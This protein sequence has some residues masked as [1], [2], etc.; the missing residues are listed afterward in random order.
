MGGREYSGK[1][2]NGQDPSPF[3]GILNLHKEG[4]CIVCV[5][6]NAM[7]FDTSQLPTP[8]SLSKTLQAPLPPSPAKALILPMMECLG[9]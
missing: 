7:H 3:L 5:H 1:C 9:I 6:M 2:S 4:K 8:H